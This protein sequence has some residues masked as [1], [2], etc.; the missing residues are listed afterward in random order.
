MD[1]IAKA[2]KKEMSVFNRSAKKHAKDVSPDWTVECYLCGAVP[3]VPLTEMCGP[4]TWGEAET[5]EGNW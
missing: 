5:A 4:C 1:E 2:F 3:I